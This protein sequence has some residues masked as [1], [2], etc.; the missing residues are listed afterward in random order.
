MQVIDNGKDISN[1]TKN[2]YI[3]IS[4]QFSIAYTCPPIPNT[5]STS[6]V[7]KEMKTQ[8]KSTFKIVLKSAL[9]QLLPKYLNE[10]AR[11]K[12]Q[13]TQLKTWI[14]LGMPKKS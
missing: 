14:K 7:E 8:K 12:I 2:G 9:M 5:E 4:I 13:N 11:I 10:T 3:E 6:T 1:G